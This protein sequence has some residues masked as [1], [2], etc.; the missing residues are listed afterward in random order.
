MLFSG[1]RSHVSPSICS[2]NLK[3]VGAETG[4]R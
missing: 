1:T 3:A 2:T 4:H